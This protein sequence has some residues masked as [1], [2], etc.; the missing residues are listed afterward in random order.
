[1]REVLQHARDAYA[2]PDL[3][4][5]VDV[6]ELD[7]GTLEAVGLRVRDVVADGVQILRGGVEATQC[8][9]K[10]HVCAPWKTIVGSED[11][12]NVAETHLV[13]D[14]TEVEQRSVQAGAD[15]RDECVVQTG[16]VH[17]LAAAGGLDRNGVRP[18]RRLRAVVELAVPRERLGAGVERT[19]IETAHDF[20]GAI[21]DADLHVVG[22]RAEFETE[23]RGGAI[24]ADQHAIARHQHALAD[25]RRGLQRLAGVDLAGDAF[26]RGVEVLDAA[27]RVDLGQLRGHLRVVHRVQR[28]LVLQLR[29]QQGHEV[30]LQVACGV[31]LGGGAGVERA[32]HARIDRL[33]GGNGHQPSPSVRVL[34]IIC[35][36]VFSTSTL[37]WYEREASIMLTISSTGWTLGRLTYPWS[38]AFGSPG[39]YSRRSG[40][41]S[42]T[43]FET[44]TPA[45]PSRP[46]ASNTTCFARYG[47]PSGPA[48]LSALARLLAA[49]FMR[50]D[51]AC[52]A[53]PEIWKIENMVTALSL[54]R[55]HRSLEIADAGVDQAERGFVADGVV[56][57]RGAFD[58]HVHGVAIEARLIGHPIQHFGRRTAAGRRTPQMAGGRG[59]HR[60]LAVRAV[61]RGGLR[62][63]P[64]KVEIARLEIGR[65][66][67]GDVAGQHLLPFEAQT[68][69][70]TIEVQCRSELVEHVRPLL[71]RDDV[72]APS[73][74]EVR[75]REY[76]RGC[77][78]N[79][80][81]RPGFCIQFGCS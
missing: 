66:G 65:V 48:T 37:A 36:L 1:I 33:R 15:A 78:S 61:T 74:V 71:P 73:V 76:A 30:V 10:T 23:R 20:S 46:R 34:V 52:M 19:E 12:P 42:S 60:Q 67:V 14:A 31:R 63:R 55:L 51:W 49:T 22:S 45:E 5:G 27:D 53:E 32:Q 72:G 35:L 24:A 58:I 39:R 29:D 69:R 7:T 44:P 2:L 6:R 17:R 80:T 50:C 79:R 38:S 43:T 68:Q 21:G 13:G 28:I 18:L 70:L 59:G 3:R 47:W 41:A 11:L 75:H 56:G 26:Q 81:N 57:E 77:R 40:V 9:R 62:Q 16:D 8:L 4:A 54:F 25:Q 64:R